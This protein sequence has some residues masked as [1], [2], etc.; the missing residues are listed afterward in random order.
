MFMNIAMKF[1]DPFFKLVALGLSVAYIFQVFLNIG[2]AIKF[3][4]S[5]GVTLPLVSYGMSSVFSTLICFAIVQFVYILVSKE[6]DDFEKERE[7]I[8]YGEG[9]QNVSRNET[10]P[11]KRTRKSKEK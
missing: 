11:G 6:A 8:A 3:I 2:G 9:S 10:V 4:P 1:E 5:T 7:R